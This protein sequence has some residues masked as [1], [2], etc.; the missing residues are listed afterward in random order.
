MAKNF[1]FPNDATGQAT[2]T[3][4]TILAPLLTKLEKKGS[5]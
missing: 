1:D 3:M 2:L 4:V 5:I